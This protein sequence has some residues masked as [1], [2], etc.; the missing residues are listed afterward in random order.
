VSCPRTS[1]LQYKRSRQH[2]GKIGTALGADYLIEGT[3]L[4]A[5]ERI[6]ITAQLISAAGDHHVW[7]ETYD[8]NL[9]GILEVQ[10]EIARAIAAQVRIQLT[11]QDQARLTPPDAVSPAALQKYFQGRYHWNKRTPDGLRRSREFFMEALDIEPNYALAWAGLADAHN[12]LGSYRLVPMKESHP[13]ARAAAEK[14]IRLND[15]L[16]EAHASLA[17]VITDYYWDWPLAEREFR[18]AIDLYP[19]Y[20]TVHLWYS[21]Y[22]TMMGRHSEALAEVNQAV[23]L[24]PLSPVMHGNRGFVLYYGGRYR[25]AIAEQQQVLGMEPALALARIILGLA[26]IQQGMYPQAVAQFQT[27]AA[28]NS[29]VFTP[30]LG[31]AHAKAGQRTEALRILGDLRGKKN[32]HSFSLAYLSL[33]LGNKEEALGL[34]ERAYEEHDVLIGLVK[35][36]PDLAPIR[37]EKRFVNLL[38]KLNLHR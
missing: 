8:R 17:T 38:K 4:P 19:N 15:N 32:T 36:A 25:E 6:R 11:P 13:Q 26:Y 29:P 7:A 24:D 30:L 14:A 18:R 20:A 34:L 2:I 22:L 31:Y 23:D 3:V 21:N 12:L 27:I 16:A 35:V 5:G 28:S 10:S 37:G 33:A 9:T 1:V